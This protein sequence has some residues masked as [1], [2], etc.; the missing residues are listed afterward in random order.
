[1]PFLAQWRRTRQLVRSEQILGK[2]KHPDD[3]LVIAVRVSNRCVQFDFACDRTGRGAREDNRQVERLDNEATTGSSQRIN[4]L[5]SCRKRER[6]RETEYH[7]E[8]GVDPNRTL[9]Y[10]KLRCFLLVGF[11]VL[12][13]WA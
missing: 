11:G 6:E 9:C 7:R 10:S 2:K 13:F 12:G 3:L 8:A 5:T 4:L 1:M